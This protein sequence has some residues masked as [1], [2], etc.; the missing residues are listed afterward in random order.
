M[1]VALIDNMN[2]MLFTITRYLR[3]RG[4][5]AELLTFDMPGNNHFVPE[6]DTFTN[7]H[8]SFV[9]E[10]SWGGQVRNFYQTKKST[11]AQDLEA[12]D[13]LIGA[14]LIPAYLNKLGTRSLDLM[15]PYGGD[16]YDLP[17]PNK[18]NSWKDILKNI[19]YFPYRKHQK[20][21]IKNSK[22][23]SFDPHSE[24]FLEWLTKLEVLQQNVY[25]PPP[26]VYDGEY[27]LQHITNHYAK[28]KLYKR[29]K[30]IRDNN[31]LVVF[32]HL[33]HRICDDPLEY[34][35][36]DK[37]IKAF[38]RFVKANPNTKAA[39]VTFEY[40]Q[41]LENSKAL[42]KELGINQYVHWF[43]ASPRKEIMVGLSMADITTGEFNHGFNI[44]GVVWESLIA[45]VPIMLYRDEQQIND[46]KMLY[47]CLNAKGEN[48]IYEHLV[49][50]NKDKSILKKIGQEGYTWVK[51]QYDDSID[52]IIELIKLK[53]QGRDVSEYIQQYKAAKNMN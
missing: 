11:I 39:L 53:E 21:G 34:K 36:N 4:I 9:K 14:G 2:N 8:K 30:E 25:I 47:P 44:Y 24:L 45:G 32:H 17:F 28:S 37:L 26:M 27:A 5:D 46:K 52:T 16:L 50:I 35:G 15:I 3:D 22:I 12:Y 23:I 38:A 42:V 43:P 13:F 48:D 41:E 19:F 18:I 7:D 40:G 51:Q 6:N 10:I 29:F 20:Q 1:K 31:D 49:T 33:R